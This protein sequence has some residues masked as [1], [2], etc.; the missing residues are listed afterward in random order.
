MSA[1]ARLAPTTFYRE[2]ARNRRRS[3]LLVATVMVVL[4][5]LGGVIG[6]ATGLGWGGI[7]LA[8]IEETRRQA[9]GTAII[10]RGID[11]LNLCG[12]P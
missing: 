9:I 10:S 12:E 1:E 7:V 4:G 3:W 6:Y 5:L 2:I 8:G 11:L